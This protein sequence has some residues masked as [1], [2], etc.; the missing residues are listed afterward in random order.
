MSGQFED[1]V[2]LVTGAAVAAQPEALNPNSDAGTRNFL[3]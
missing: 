1:K 3:P 2:V